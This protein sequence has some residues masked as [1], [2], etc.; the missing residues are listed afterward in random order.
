MNRLEHEVERLELANLLLKDKKIV[1]IRYST[2]EEIK[3]M[4]WHEAFI[5]FRTED[6]VS[7][8]PSR[9]LKGNEAGVIF[10]QEPVSLKGPLLFHE[11]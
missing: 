6:G 10:L 7:F 1:E 4:G 3:E 5:I 11:F 9:D 8:Y 2:K